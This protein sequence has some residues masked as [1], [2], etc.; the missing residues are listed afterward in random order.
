MKNAKEFL[1]ELQALC[2]K[3]KVKFTSTAGKADND[4]EIAVLTAEPDGC[5]IEVRNLKA[6]GRDRQ[7][8][9]RVGVGKFG[10]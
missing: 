2:F 10:S 9:L 7:R 5:V 6:I 8:R 1:V 4:G 3:H